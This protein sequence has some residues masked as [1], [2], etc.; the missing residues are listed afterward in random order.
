MGAFFYMLE[1][2]V[3]WSRAGGAMSTWRLHAPYWATAP[4]PG[5][6]PAHPCCPAGEAGRED[7]RGR[8]HRNGMHL[9]R[10]PCQTLNLHRTLNLH[11]HLR[12]AISKAT[13]SKAHPSTML[14]RSS[15][16][17]NQTPDHGKNQQPK[18]ACVII[19]FQEL[20]RHRGGQSRPGL[21]QAPLRP[22]SGGLSN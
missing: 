16:R 15:R 5:G 10:I 7:R 13:V 9:W 4:S 8:I 21:E 6:V 12:G 14:K 20:L 3:V 11:P 1:A 17:R 22:G 18:L 2:K 19:A